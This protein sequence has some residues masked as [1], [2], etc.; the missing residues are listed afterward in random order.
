MRTQLRIFAAVVFRSL[1]GK[2]AS[3]MH[4]ADVD[5]DGELT[6]DDGHAAYTRIAPVVRK[7]TA[8]TGGL[9]GGFVLAYSGLK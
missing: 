9:V 5:G 4:H 7:H 6:M 8:L 1:K 2:L 3:A